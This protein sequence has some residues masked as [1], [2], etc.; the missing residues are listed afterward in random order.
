M[1]LDE[2]DALVERR[3]HGQLLLNSMTG[4]LL[5]LLESFDGA[6]FITSNRASAF[7]PAALSRVTLAIRYKPLDAAAKRAIWAN[8]LTRVLAD[9]HGAKRTHEEARRLATEEFDLGHLAQF[10][11]SGR[12]VGSVVRLAIGLC[13]QRQCA[14]SQRVLEDAINV[15]NAFHA[16]LRAEG[17]QTTWETL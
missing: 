15:F 5:R 8:T 12:A 2:G 10:N 3:R 17:A 14:L 4:V 13:G 16:E 1:L 11:G 9:E 7:D 6:L